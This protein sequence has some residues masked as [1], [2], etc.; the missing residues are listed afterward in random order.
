RLTPVFQG[1][2]PEKANY[3]VTYEA[4]SEGES[5]L[6]ITQSEF[7]RRMKDMSALGGGM[8][9]Y[10]EMPDSYNLVVNGNHPL[11]LRVNDELGKKL[12]GELKKIDDKV[13]PLNENKAELDK[14]VKDK[15]EEEIKQEEKDRIEELTK[16]IAELEEKKTKLLKKFGSDNKLVK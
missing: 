11:V 4:M 16:K 12:S 13:K 6:L 9:F 5:P 2:L 7:M 8:N 10:G 3:I 1:Q 15:K 14:A